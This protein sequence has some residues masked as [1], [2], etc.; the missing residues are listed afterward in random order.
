MITE[1]E[2]KKKLSELTKEA[3]VPLLQRFFK[4]FEDFKEVEYSDPALALQIET[5]IQ[6]LCGML[7]D[8][9]NKKLVNKLMK[10]EAG[11]QLRWSYRAPKV[12]KDEDEED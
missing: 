11:H 8:E 1:Q 4:M 5:K 2:V 6:A 10:N 3:H 12:E 7:K 9:D